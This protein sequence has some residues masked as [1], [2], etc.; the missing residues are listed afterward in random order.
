[1]FATALP[2]IFCLLL[3]GNLKQVAS[4]LSTDQVEEHHLNT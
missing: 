2:I 3:Y 4:Q 1:M